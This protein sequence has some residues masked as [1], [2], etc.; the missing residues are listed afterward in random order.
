MADKPIIKIHNNK[1]RYVLSRSGMWVRDFTRAAI[2]QDINCLVKPDD[3]QL[4][5]DN[6]RVNTGSNIANI[7][8]ETIHARKVVIVSDG[9]GF[10]EKQKILSSLSDDVV[11][12]GVN[13]SLA[14]WGSYRRMDW[15][16]ANNP[17][18][19]CVTMLPRHGYYPRCIVSARTNP[20][21]VKTYRSRSGVMYKY[22]PVED[23]NFSSRLGGTPSFAVDDY[24]NPICAAIGIA[25][26]W[27]VE[28]LMFMCC[29]DV[30]EDERPGAE[31]LPNGMWQYPQHNLSHSLIE[32]M[33]FWLM[34]QKYNK[35]LIANHSA[36]PEYRGVPYLA[37]DR[38]AVFFS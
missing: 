25:Y 22:A 38:I 32:G 35:V 23:K 30:F 10:D 18:E 17:Y 11:V 5:Y 6:E 21:F 12:I 8:A 16:L 37:E 33:T 24:R 29:D 13:H 14:K 20:D 2:P 27:G 7:D 15:F 9:Y 31:Q 28:R 34:V 4:L 3:Y 1:N 36:G 19:D 26:R